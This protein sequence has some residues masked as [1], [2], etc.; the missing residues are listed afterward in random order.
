LLTLAAANA[1]AGGT[2]ISAGSLAL[3]NDAAPGFGPI[4]ATGQGSTPPVTGSATFLFA[5]NGNRLLTNA[6]RVTGSDNTVVACDTTGGNLTLSGGLLS[7]NADLAKT[8][9]NTLTF[10]NCSVQLGRAAGF[11]IYSGSLVLDGVTWLNGNLGVTGNDGFRF[12]NPTAGDLL[13]VTLTN[14]STLMVDNGGNLVLGAVVAS[15]NATNVFTLASG[16]VLLAADSTVASSII[17]GNAVGATASSFNQD[18]GTVAWTNATLN[19]ASALALGNAASTL[20]IYNL[21]GGILQAP[22][23]KQGAGTGIFNFNGGTLKPVL[24]SPNLSGLM[25]GLTAANVLANGAVFD[26]AG[27]SVTVNQPLLDGGSG[28]GLAKNGAGTLTL[29]GANTYAGPTAINQGTLALGASGSLGNSAL[30]SLAGGATLDVSALGGTF[31]LGA[32][33]TLAGNGTVVGSVLAASGATVA[34]GASPGA[35]T[36]S[37]NLV[38]GAGSTNVMELDKS[39]GTNDVI[40]AGAITFG[41]TLIVNNLNTAPVGGDSFKLFN[42]G[43]YA[44][45]FTVTSLPSLG[46]ALNWYLG[47][48]ATDGRLVVNRAPSVTN[49]TLGVISSV[50]ATIDLM[51]GKNAPTDADGDAMTL[52]VNSPST[53]G[54][55][56]TTD[57]TNV[58]YTSAA[59]YLGTDSFTYSVADGRGGVSIATVSVTVNDGRAQNI[60]SLSKTGD[61]VLI[62]FAGIPGY[63]YVVETTTN[64]LPTTSWRPL[65]TNTAGTNGLWQFSDPNATNVSQFYR[66]RMP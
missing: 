53:A 46:V 9:P 15:S 22:L 39:G 10:A 38:F 33:Q 18:G 40:N 19:G 61:T 47:S 12:R 41:G 56:V 42:A 17:L 54:G 13:T 55:T 51:N 58:T 48:L 66:S 52:T 21:N 37:A 1:H 5:T 24:A 63:T 62:T 60:L 49:F 50:P 45:S 14:G 34:P 25:Q 65:G 64:A 11:D 3:G 20:G 28:G 31:S 32:G 35:L 16:Q 59:G 8:G 23:I 57:G 4:T 36:F 6:V 27:A 30:F 29:G 2:T 44:G 43:S 26:T 7:T